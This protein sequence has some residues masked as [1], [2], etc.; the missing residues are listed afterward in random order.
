MVVRS[1][2]E[3]VDGTTYYSG[4]QAKTTVEAALYRFICRFNGVRSK[5]GRLYNN[6]EAMRR[7]Y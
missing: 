4:V 1:I 7:N 6:S 3:Q 2:K 5:V